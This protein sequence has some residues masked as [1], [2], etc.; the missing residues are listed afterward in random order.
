[1][2]VAPEN[3]HVP[4][5]PHSARSPPGSQN[6][7]SVF[8]NKGGLCLLLWVGW[9]GRGSPASLGEG[10]ACPLVQARCCRV[11]RTGHEVPLSLVS[12]GEML[13]WKPPLAV[14]GSCMF[15]GRF[16]SNAHLMCFKRFMYQLSILTDKQR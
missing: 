4:E 16:A 6:C 9:E 1:M 3:R 11:L 14:G 7:L 8:Y 10:W 5:I 15:M 12:A 13:R 2:Y